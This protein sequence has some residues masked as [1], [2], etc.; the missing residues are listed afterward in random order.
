MQSKLNYFFFSP[1][2]S[3]SGEAGG[4]KMTKRH[5]CQREG[6]VDILF[7]WTS[8]LNCNFKMIALSYFDPEIRDV[9]VV[10]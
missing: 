4:K 5:V 1:F 9:V 8:A 7:F 2:L 10:D 6:E 3:V